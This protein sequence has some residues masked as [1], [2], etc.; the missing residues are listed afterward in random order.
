MNRRKKGI[1]IIG[2]AFVTIGLLTGCA[3][4][5]E[6]TLKEDKPVEVE[7]KEQ[8]MLEEVPEE[9]SEE[10]SK[11]NVIEIS[12]YEM[13]YTPPTVTLEEGQEY[14][15][16]LKNDGEIFHDLTANK[17]DV[18]IT[19]MGD[20]PDHP[21]DMTFNDA[22]DK[23]LGVKKAHADGGDDTEE[24]MNYIHMNAEAGQT[25]EIKFIP[26]ETGEFKFYCS[27]PGHEE[28]GMHGEIEVAN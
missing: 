24:K 22:L 3:S 12:A 19:N 2:S 14:T 6:A 11:D 20:M 5:E 17:L 8:P 10:T 4:E 25:V 15:L 13:G 28:S 7:V 18:E 23:I 1:F 9:I 26:K 27:V 16:V 21:E